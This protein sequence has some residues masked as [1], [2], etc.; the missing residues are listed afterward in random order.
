MIFRGTWNIKCPAIV[1]V[2]SLDV[3]KD[4]YGICCRVCIELKPLN[5]LKIPHAD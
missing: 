2:S 1:Q 3:A 4:I 5:G